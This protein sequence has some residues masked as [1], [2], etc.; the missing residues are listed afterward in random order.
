VRTD[1]P[2]PT[3]LL[4]AIALWAVVVWVLAIAGL[5]GRIDRLPADPGLAQGL[6]AVPAPVADRLGPPDA[7]SGFS[8]RPLFLPDRRP[9]PFFLDP[10]DG[11]APATFDYVLTSVLLVPGLEVAIVQPAGGGEPVRLKVGEAPEGAADW[12]LASVSPRG[13][14]F[15]GPGGQRSLELRVY[16]GVGGQAPT[17]MAAPAAAP[18][19]GARPQPRGGSAPA[20]AVQDAAAAPAPT[21][22][23]ASPPEA[24]RR[25]PEPEPESAAAAAPEPD[26][27]TT[28]DEQVEAIRARIEARR[29]RMREQE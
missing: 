29:A 24:G 13:A 15:D 3:W 23:P 16:D 6:P 22:V 19:P 10:A 11:D 4:G 5:G 17:A 21:P 18:A 8:E 25:K 26:A 14:V 1:A 20:G 2:A 27:V 7:Y 12:R 9:Q 28:A